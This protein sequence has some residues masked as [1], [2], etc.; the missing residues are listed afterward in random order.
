MLEGEKQIETALNEAGTVASGELLKQ[1]DSDGSAIQ[2]GSIKLTSKGQIEKS[3]Q[4]PYGETRLARH[5][6]QSPQ[7]GSTYCPL[8]HHARIISNATP[9]LSKMLSH[10]YSKLS[11][12]EVKGDLQSNHGRALSRGYI[13]KVSEAVGS[14]AQAKAERVN[15]KWT[16]NF[17]IASISLHL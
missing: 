11:T 13:Q 9:K 2:V 1:F 10:K 17:K 5:V 14:L 7:G 3:Y 12:D 16:V 15:L 8:E 6:Y 4:T